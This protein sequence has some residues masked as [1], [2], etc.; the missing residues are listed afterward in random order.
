MWI[1]RFDIG[2]RQIFCWQA[3]M[4]GDK[5]SEMILKALEPQLMSYM[6]FPYFFQKS[7]CFS[8]WPSPIWLISIPGLFLC[9]VQRSPWKKLVNLQDSWQMEV[10]PSKILHNRYWSI[11]NYSINKKVPAKSFHACGWCSC[12]HNES[13]KCQNIDVPSRR[14]YPRIC[15]STWTE[16]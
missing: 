12:R 5:K 15:E 7:P 6:F 3:R 13:G 10:H 2:L 8:T 14:G 1:N 16:N 11:A 4:L 9:S